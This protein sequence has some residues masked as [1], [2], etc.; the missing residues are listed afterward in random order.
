MNKQKT[1]VIIAC[2]KKALNKTKVIIVCGKKSFEMENVR[3]T[4]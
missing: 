2:G 4:R 1:K 3:M